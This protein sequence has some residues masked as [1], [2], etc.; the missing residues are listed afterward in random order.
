[1]PMR[2]ANSDDVL[3]I[4]GMT[5]AAAPD[6]ATLEALVRVENGLAANLDSKI[7]MSFGTAPT[8]E[9]RSFSPYGVQ[10]SWIGSYWYPLHAFDPYAVGIAA[11]PDTNTLIFDVPVRSIASIETGG[12]WDGSTWTGGVVTAADDFMLVYPDDGAYWGVKHLAGAW[13]GV[14]RVT[15]IWNDQP[16]GG[17]VPDDV[18]QAMNLLTADH[19]RFERADING[20]LGPNNQPVRARNPWAHETVLEVISKYRVY[21]LAV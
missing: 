17:A 10:V 13:S 16:N 5:G 1:M 11:Y 7:G 18:R 6:A 15:G 4:L 20:V 14:V 3:N 9:T 19:W 8:P 12:S 2:Y 21:E